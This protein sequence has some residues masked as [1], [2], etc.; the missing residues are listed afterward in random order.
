MHMRF[1]VKELLVVLMAGGLV[2]GCA[3]TPEAEPAEEEP[4]AEERRT[5]DGSYTVRRGDSLWAISARGEVYGNPYKWPLIF[6]ANS[7]T[8]EDADLIFPGQ[9]LSYPRDVS[10]S[11]EDAA[12]RH[13]RTRGEWSLGRTEESDQRYLGRR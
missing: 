4:R 10:R 8:I 3:S 6:R 11:D 9:D 13:A 2:V 5:A 1:S 12:V 7:N